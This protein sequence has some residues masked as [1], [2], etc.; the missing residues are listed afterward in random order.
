MRTM[1]LWTVPVDPTII[2]EQETFE[3][4]ISYYFP[5][6]KIEPPGSEWLASKGSA[7]G[8]LIGSALIG[9]TLGAVEP[10]VEP[11]GHL[12]PDGPR[13]DQRK[14][15][16]NRGEL[17]PNL[18]RPSTNKDYGPRIELK[19]KKINSWMSK[20]KNVPKAIKHGIQMHA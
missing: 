13:P 2:L 12:R 3:E 11:G 10:G 5:C 15:S 8:A 4:D 19:G 1:D 6:G 9:S 14:S 18:F 16:V 17:G 7:L 20:I